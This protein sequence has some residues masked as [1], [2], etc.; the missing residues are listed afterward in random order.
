MV[1]E[2]MEIKELDKSSYVYS[3]VLFFILKMYIAQEKMRNKW[4]DK[5]L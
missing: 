3:I 5:S 4:L 2:K 1:Q